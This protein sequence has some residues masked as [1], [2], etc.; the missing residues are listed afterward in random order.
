MQAIWDTQSAQQK[1]V[2]QLCAMVAAGDVPAVQVSATVR[3]YDAG[4]QQQPGSPCVS[5]KIWTCSCRAC[6]L[7]P[8]LPCLQALLKQQPGL[9]A[10]RAFD[11]QT[12]APPHPLPRLTGSHL[13]LGG[14]MGPWLGRLHSTAAAGCLG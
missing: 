2:Q 5:R 8:C 3:E 7:P 10:D 13:Q 6:L 12:G 11:V 14:S 9:L 1:A 4:E